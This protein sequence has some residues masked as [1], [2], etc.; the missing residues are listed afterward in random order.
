MAVPIVPPEV[1]RVRRTYEFAVAAAVFTVIV[2]ATSVAF[3]T[4]GAFPV[5]GTLIDPKNVVVAVLLTLKRLPLVLVATTKASPV[6]AE[7]VIESV[8]YGVVVPIPTLPVFAW[9]TKRW[10]VFDP[11]HV[12][13]A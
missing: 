9:T 10:V 1:F 12:E 8:A 2:P 4:I 6:V 11:S 13:I 7:V 5:D 3:P